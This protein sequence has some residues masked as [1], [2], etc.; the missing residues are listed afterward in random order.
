ME[1]LLHPFLLADIL[2]TQ[3]PWY[4]PMVDMT[5]G[6]AFGWDDLETISKDE[7]ERAIYEAQW[8]YDSYGAK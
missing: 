1:N 3:F 6:S 2:K 5:I 4:N 8:L 7:K